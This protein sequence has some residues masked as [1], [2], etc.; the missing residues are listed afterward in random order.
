MEIAERRFRPEFQVAFDAWLATSPETNPQAPP[1]PTYMPEYAQ[2][3]FAEAAALDRKADAS[4]AEGSAAGE[5]SDKYV[6][7]TV[8]LASV[9]FLVGISTHFPYRGVRYALVGLGGSVL[10]VSLVLMS[11]L[12]L[13]PR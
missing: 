5:A 8:F 12:P 13:P 4:F 3:G 9:L 7:V 2:P 11:Q 10:V 6:R 1:G